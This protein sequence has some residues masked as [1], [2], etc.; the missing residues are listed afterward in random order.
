MGKA[1]Q[2][3]EAIKVKIITFL[4]H[5]SMT[6]QEI[7]REC[8]VSQQAVSLIIKKHRE[9]G[10][11]AVAPSSGRPRKTTIRDD[12]MIA[13]EIKKNPFITSLEIKAALAPRLDHVAPRT[14][15]SR[16]S[17][18]LNMRARKPGMKPLISKAARLKRLSWCRQYQSWT[19][20]EWKRDIFSDESTFTLLT[21]THQHVRLP[22][23]A[24]PLDL[25]K[26]QAPHVFATPTPVH[27]TPRAELRK[28]LAQARETIKTLKLEAFDTKE[29]IFYEELMEENEQL[30]NQVAELMVQ[31][32]SLQGKKNIPSKNTSLDSG[33]NSGKP[34][35]WE[36]IQQELTVLHD[37]QVEDI[38]DEAE[39]RSHLLK[40]VKAECESQKLAMEGML[41]QLS[42]ERELRHKLEAKISSLQEELTQAQEMM[43]EAQASKP[44]L[45]ILDASSQTW[46]SCQGENATAM[47]T[48][49][50]VDVFVSPIKVDH[51]QFTQEVGKSSEEN[52]PCKRTGFDSETQTEEVEG[53]VHKA[54]KTFDVAISPIQGSVRNWCE[55]K[56][57]QTLNALGVFHIDA[58]TQTMQQQNSKT[59][60]EETQTEENEA[61]VEIQALEKFEDHEATTS[62][63]L[64]QKDLINQET[65]VPEKEMVDCESQTFGKCDM[66]CDSGTDAD[67]FTEE[68]KAVSHNSQAAQRVDVA[69]SPIRFN[70]DVTAEDNPIFPNEIEHTKVSV[71]SASFLSAAS[72]SS[73]DLDETLQ[74]DQNSLIE[75]KN[76]ANHEQIAHQSF[77]EGLENRDEMN[78][79]QM[80]LKSEESQLSITSLFRR[81]AIRNESD[82]SFTF[83]LTHDGQR[84]NVEIETL[85][86]EM[87][88]QSILLNDKEAEVERLKKNIE[89]QAQE[90]ASFKMSLQNAKEE[91]AL[92]EMELVELRSN[93]E[94]LLKQMAVLK[95]DLKLMQDLQNAYDDL[96]KKHSVLTQGNGRDVEGS[97]EKCRVEIHALE[98]KLF[99]KDDIGNVEV[100]IE[101]FTLSSQEETG[102]DSQEE[103]MATT[104]SLEEKLEEKRKHDATVIAAMDDFQELQIKNTELLEELQQKTDVKEYMSEFEKEDEPFAAASDLESGMQNVAKEDIHDVKE[105]ESDMVVHLHQEC[106]E[107]LIAMEA[108]LMELQTSKGELQDQLLKKE[109]VIQELENALNYL[110][111]EDLQKD[112]TANSYN[113]ESI[114]GGLQEELASQ[115]ESSDER[116]TALD[117]NVL[118]KGS[119]VGDLTLALESVQVEMKKQESQLCGIIMALESK[120]QE[121]HGIHECIE[122]ERN[123]VLQT[124]L[125]D[126]QTM[127]DS[128]EEKV[129]IRDEEIQALLNKINLI[130]VGK[131]NKEMDSLILEGKMVQL[132]DS[133]NLD[134]EWKQST[135]RIAVLESQL[136]EIQ[137]QKDLLQ[138]ES[139]MLNS[140]LQEA[141]Y[142]LGVFEQERKRQEEL[143][144]TI[145]FL[146]EELDTCRESLTAQSQ[147]MMALEEREQHLREKVVELEKENNQQSEDHNDILRALQQKV[148][149]L[150]SSKD[151]LEEH[152]TIKDKELQE[153]Q[154]YLELL[155]QEQEGREVKF[156]SKMKEL[157][158][159][160]EE[161]EKLH[162]EKLSELEMHLVEVEE[163]KIILEGQTKE[164]ETQIQELR[165]HLEDLQEVSRE[166][167]EMAVAMKDLVNKLQAL[168]EEHLACGQEKLVLQE[169]EQQLHVKIAELEGKLMQVQQEGFLPTDEALP[170]SQEKQELV[171]TIELLQGKLKEHEETHN[172]QSQEMMTLEE[173]EQH[174]KEKIVE[175]EKKN[176][177]QSED[178]ND[179]LRALQQK[180]DELQSSKDFLEEHITIKDKELQELQNDLELLKLK[181]EGREVEFLSKMKELEMHLAE[182]EESKIILEGQT[183]EKETQ[184]QELRSHLEDL[185]EVS[186]ERDEM[187]VAM[188][189]LENK[190]QALVE[191]HLTYGQEK[192]VL[193]KEEQ[194]L[195][196]KIA[197]LEGKLMQVQQ[198]GFLPTDEALPESQEKQEMVAT[199]ELLQ[200]KLKELEETHN[201][202]SQEMMTLE[203][204][205]QHLKEKIV[206]LEKK[207]NQ[208]SE[209]HNDI[210]R[211]L[212]Q[213]VDELQ[214]SKDF[215]EEHITIKDKE[216]QELQNHLELLKQEQEGREVD[217]LFKIKELQETQEGLEK[218]H[219]EKLSELEMHLVE[220][221][222]SKIILEGQ[223]KEKETQIQ[224][225]RSYLKDL[226]EVSRERDEMA[227]AMKDLENKLQA[228]VEEHLA[229]GQ[230]KQV[231]QEEEQQLHVKIAELE[232]KLLQVQQDC[233]EYKVSMQ[234]VQVQFDEFHTCRKELEADIEKKES[235]IQDL[236]KDLQAVQVLQKSE[237]C[238]ISTVTSLESE[239]AQLLVAIDLHQKKKEEY[240]DKIVH[241]ENELKKMIEEREENEQKFALIVVEMV[242]VKKVWN[243]CEEEIIHLKKELVEVKTCKEQLEEGIR[244][245]DVHS[246]ELKA[247]FEALSEKQRIENEE[248]KTKIE[249]LLE[250]LEKL[251]EACHFHEQRAIALDLLLTD[252]KVQNS[253]LEEKVSSFETLTS[254]L[255]EIETF[256]VDLWN[257]STIQVP[258]MK[259]QFQEERPVVDLS[260]PLR[261]RVATWKLAIQSQVDGMQK[262]LTEYQDKI[263]FSR[264][265]RGEV[266]Q[267][268]DA[269]DKRL[270]HAIKKYDELQLKYE[271]LQKGT[272][273]T[274][275]VQDTFSICKWCEELLAELWTLAIIPNSEFRYF[276]KSELQAAD[277][278]SPVEKRLKQLG[279]QVKDQMRRLVRAFNKIDRASLEADKREQTYEAEILKLNELYSDLKSES[280]KWQVEM[281]KKDRRINE[282]V[283]RLT[284]LTEGPE[285]ENECIQ[286]MI[287]I[288]DLLKDMWACVNQLKQDYESQRLKLLENY[289]KLEN[290]ERT[291]RSLEAERKKMSKECARL[292]Q[293][294]Q[295]FGKQ[296]LDSSIVQ[297][298]DETI[299]LGPT[300][301]PLEQEKATVL[302]KQVESLQN[303]LHR[304]N[305][306]IREKKHLL[307]D[308][309]PIQAEI[310]KEAFPQN[311]AIQVPVMQSLKSTL[312]NDHQAQ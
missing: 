10:S 217:F 272:Q 236:E 302:Q 198:E 241:L 40:E 72:S 163:S 230:E 41:M 99:P 105:V 260:I 280:Q 132:Q 100:S 30:H 177:Q 87:E 259:M 292:K 65:Q 268:N 75:T 167:D 27:A 83:D 247:K 126:L 12:K 262:A 141:K 308:Q 82:V 239:N 5:T 209:D 224:E 62:K 24:S 203:E 146:E 256:L 3:T 232:G 85:L 110:Q 180:V 128:L 300:C 295:E 46:G 214:S 267:K 293:A 57:I 184:I 131:H 143:V 71:E 81:L 250:N 37:V 196:V 244:I 155:K 195:H 115:E 306:R 16:L 219:Q 19:A 112:M 119:I 233:D 248:R 208:Q 251:K 304:L 73:L 176:N 34:E 264:R 120:L 111:K 107:K 127:R 309:P 170:E 23:G 122:S 64:Q 200:G 249:E 138:K 190:L 185:Q 254:E 70:E 312:G 49:Q 149:E 6:Q 114:A 237:E 186:R 14:I 77:G 42:S 168:L 60:D 137:M 253:Q 194:Q 151:F 234:H 2:L 135:E 182:V 47:Y 32:N 263:E 188:K 171:A 117:V 231:L 20:N 43:K 67:G 299:R 289:Q 227:V 159:T 148:D 173:R 97:A 61:V 222:E 158:E 33:V 296:E 165:S 9:T 4:G 140:E 11:T 92:R 223:T 55:S 152:I 90:V 261:D 288:E 298:R 93:Q 277:G 79:S 179:I 310:A 226:Q 51:Q 118:C 130:Q 125:K 86:Q 206:E 286:V 187:A 58:M 211:A 270:R 303:E 213:K 210:L 279:D 285:K 147:E 98:D 69:L 74:A 53:L 22:P 78:L 204:R 91:G 257:K 278:N 245:Q 95:E 103:M 21:N 273:P 134:Q 102:S 56:E 276:Q 136:L 31:V 225:L 240:E 193:Q 144:K 157:Q 228:L 84:L 169:E 281:R 7:A 235:V 265:Q 76:D 48:S 215:L 243:S 191:E 50:K 172:A 17:A 54:L 301:F 108:A 255:C 1:K 154:N 178:H 104:K 139:N 166:R 269:L 66:K 26:K 123:S 59:M 297:G 96:C 307:G 25:R 36:S 202:Q 192:Q 164:K 291:K 242:E 305:E 129:Q 201:A 8:G 205:E 18:E 274:Q 52:H 311:G 238:L 68:A 161:L 174:L 142:V 106:T 160:Q 153:L 94:A 38:E 101:C 45:L 145:E 89:S 197:E 124:E 162:Q 15:L 287:V 13:R 116:A 156:L 183:K 181:Q 28:R 88:E 199:I 220:V 80:L 229:C 35:E 63:S 39:E 212:Q 175:L 294:L 284:V 113:L 44:P 275:E 133:Q 121:Q 218:L 252:L 258:R 290:E 221:E 216:L 109:I 246:L 266:V 282:L 207:N 29:F 150:Q 271:T 189:D 283:Q